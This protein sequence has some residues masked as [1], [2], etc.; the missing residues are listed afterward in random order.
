MWNRGIELAQQRSL[1]SN[2]AFL[3]DDIKIGP[4][5]LSRLGA[6]LRADERLA[7]VSPN[8]DGRELQGVQEVQEICA[9]RYDGTGGI[10]GFAFMLRGETNY[11]FPKQLNWWFGDNHLVASALLNGWRC[12]IVGAATCEHIDGGSQ[13]AEYTD[14]EMQRLIAAD[15]V[16]FENWVQQRTKVEA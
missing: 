7:I 8:Y 3:N 6:A 14:P 16:W 2:V 4:R 9:G 15:Q 13:T 11:R 12:G 10:A 1:R 5:F